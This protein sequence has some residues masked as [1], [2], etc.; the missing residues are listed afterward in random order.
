MVVP[1]SDEKHYKSIEEFKELNV[2]VLR[3]APPNRMLKQ[4]KFIN[5]TPLGVS[6]SIAKMLEANRVQAWYDAE[7]IIEYHF[8]KNNINASNFRIALVDKKMSFYIAFSKDLKEEFTTWQEAFEQMKKN[9]E[10]KKIRRKY[11]LK[12]LN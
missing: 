2:G 10:L 8:L 3:N 12:T 5:L 6:S 7:S 11:E 1:S 9:G 4:K